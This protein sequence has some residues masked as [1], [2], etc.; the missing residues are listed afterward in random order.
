MRI[1][2]SMLRE[3]EQSIA[4]DAQA[5]VRIYA[6]G[7]D[8]RVTFNDGMREMNQS[9][10]AEQLAQI[11]EYRDDKMRAVWDKLIKKFQGIRGQ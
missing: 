3:L 1:T 5:E 11:N 9:L 6:G 10:G 8:I 2:T 4:P 7:C